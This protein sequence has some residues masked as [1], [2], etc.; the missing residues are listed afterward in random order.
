MRFVKGSDPANFLPAIQRHLREKGFGN[1]K[2]REVRESR[3]A[4]TRMEP[5]DPWVEWAMESIMRTT[6]V[7]ADFLPNLSGSIPNDVFA[8]VLGLPTLWIPH[9]YAGCSQHAPNEHLLVPIVREELRVMAG[10][11]WD[12]AE[13]A[14]LVSRRNSPRSET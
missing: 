2:V 9:S 4:A 6:E 12:L 11:F 13:E 5:N 10:L 1:V 7:P 14:G 8:D 3:Y